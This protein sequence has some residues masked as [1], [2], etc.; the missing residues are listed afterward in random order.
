MTKPPRASL[1]KAGH[2]GFDPPISALYLDL[3]SNLT[4]GADTLRPIYN[5]PRK[6][7]DYRPRGEALLLYDMQR[8]LVRLRREYDELCTRIER[9]EERREE[10]QIVFNERIHAMKNIRRALAVQVHNLSKRHE[11]LAKRLEEDL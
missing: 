2:P 1:Q 11:A 4:E 8:S 10:C 9:L 6:D 3:Q 7:G 5:G